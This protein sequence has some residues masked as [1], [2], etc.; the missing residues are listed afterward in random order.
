MCTDIFDIAQKCATV[1]IAICSLYFTYFFYTNNLQRTDA[2]KKRDRNIQ[3]LKVLVLDHNFKYF[4]DFFEKIQND[5]NSLNVPNLS[6]STKG[7]INETLD[8]YFIDLRRK[9]IDSLLA[10]DDSLYNEI[11]KKFDDFQTYLTEVIFDN[12]INLAHLPKFDEKITSK[13]LILKTD[14]IKTLFNYSG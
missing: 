1:L 13:L 2:D 9:F 6:D 12:G 5:L 7:Q 11:L 8:D 4:Y 3:W 14:V 10:I